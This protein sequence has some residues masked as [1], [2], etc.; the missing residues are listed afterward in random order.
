MTTAASCLHLTPT[1]IYWA[2]IPAYAQTNLTPLIEMLI[3]DGIPCMGFI[4]PHYGN[5]GTV[6]HYA[7]GD[8]AEH[9]R[10]GFCF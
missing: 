3:L 2:A 1:H 10:K 7:E 9:P 8:W 5:D 6:K 4:M